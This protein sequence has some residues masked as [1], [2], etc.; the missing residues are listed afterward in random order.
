MGATQHATALASYRDEVTELIEEGTAFGDIEDTIDE[1]PDVT[2]DQKAA[3]WLFAFTLRDRGPKQRA[4]GAH[5]LA[6]L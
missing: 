6:V 2:S 1:F 3:L 4:S 5:L